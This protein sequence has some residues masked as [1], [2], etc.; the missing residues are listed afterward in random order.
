MS[1]RRSSECRIVFSMTKNKAF[2][3]NPTSGEPMEDSDEDLDAFVAQACARLSED[4]PAFG[5]H[6]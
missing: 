4:P 2:R 3:M 1:A 5:M 6:P